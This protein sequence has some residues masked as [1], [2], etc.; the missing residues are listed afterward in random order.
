M[1]LLINT[2]PIIKNCGLPTV[3]VIAVCTFFILSTNIFAANAV[4]KFRS[5]NTEQG[6]SSQNISCVAQDDMGYL[7][8]GTDDGLNRY[9]G[10][11]FRVFRNDPGDTLTI[12]DTR[13]TALL[14]SNYQQQPELWVGTSNGLNR[15]DLRTGH[16]TM[17][18]HDPK[19]SKSISHPVVTAIMEDADGT[20]W[21]G[22]ENGLNMLP[23]EKRKQGEFDRFLDASPE[24]ASYENW[25][26][27][28]EQGP[29]L[30]SEKQI[31]VGTRNGLKKIEISGGMDCR[32]SDYVFSGSNISA[33]E[34]DIR[35]IL[36]KRN[37]DG[38]FL[39]VGIENGDLYKADVFQL[40]ARPKK[41]WK[42]DSFIRDIEIDYYNRIWIAT[43]GGGL[44]RF[45][46]R[47]DKLYNKITFLGNPDL[48]N[49]LSNSNLS[50]LHFDLSGILWVA[51]ENGLNKVIEPVHGF[52]VLTHIPGEERSL[53][54]A[55]IRSLY[56]DSFGIL[57]VGTIANGI[58]RIDRT[59]HTY[60][61]FTAKPGQVGTIP[62]TS[63][64][65]IL[66]DLYGDM[67][68]GTWDGGL[69]K[70]NPDKETFS[71]YANDP[72]D[73]FSVPHNV[74]QGLLEDREG[75]IWLNTGAGLSRYNRK[76]NNFINYSYDP[77]D[78]T[79]ISAGDL[80]SKAMYLDEQDR[81]WVGSYGGGV[82]R[83]DL[84]ISQN[85]DPET[86]IFD[87]IR[88]DPMN[89]SSISS[90]LVISIT[91][92]ENGGREVVWIGTF[93]KGIT[94]IEITNED[95]QEK[96]QYKRY[97]ES[98]GLCDNVIF[99][100]EE[101]RHRE[102]WISTGDGLARFDPDLEHF[103]NYYVED[104]LPSNGFFWGASHQSQAGEMFFGGTEGL[105]YFSPDE[106]M[107]RQLFSPK[108]SI[109]DVRVLNRRLS[110]RPKDY[111]NV[112]LYFD[113]S[114]NLITIDWAL[115]DFIN[116]QKNSFKYRL[117]GLHDNWI[118]NGNMT[119]TT[120]SNLP[121]GN[122]TFRVKGS[123][124]NG[125]ESLL[126]AGLRLHIK[127]PFY[128]TILFQIC[129]ILSLILIIY[130]VFVIRTRVVMARNKQLL[131]INE[132][133]GLLIKK[134]E[135]A[136]EAL[137][138]SLDEKEVLLREIYHRTK[139]NMSVIISLLNLQASSIKKPR[140]TQ[141]FDEIKGR[142]FAM[143][144]VHEQL[145]K[146]KDLSVIDLNLYVRQLI[147]NLLHSYSAVG[148]RINSIIRVDHIEVS[149]DTAVPLGLVLNEI[150]TNSLKYAFPGDR[151][152]EI[153]I[154]AK[155][156]ANQLFLKI[157]DDG[158]GFNKVKLSD[159]NQTLGTR[160]IHTVI[161]DQLE[162]E[163]K[164]D[165]TSGTTYEILLKN[166]QIVRRV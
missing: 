99:G 39:Y 163:L 73:P 143:S 165:A 122:Y 121:G 125:I 83:L 55:G 97:S 86:A 68:F 110:N 27:S 115:F 46:E 132:E 19:N 108:I 2:D 112:D 36:V 84:K 3:R 123:N 142:I 31:W 24:E 70:L 69:F 15:L 102:L 20:I 128:Q 100:I 138:R 157:A 118:P 155:Y 35:S 127:P 137:Q 12:S 107:G 126:E 44:H 106:I 66:E 16:F 119:S 88:H 26:R 150:I 94:K 30:G 48:K 85:L 79:G 32:V 40:D 51:S 4:T 96:L 42:F 136:E 23:A 6:L 80:Q 87:H 159:K 161:E 33:Q 82:S 54:G 50:D 149:I 81:L 76:L 45:Q 77:Q 90:D 139:N 111:N 57:W 130:L 104:G 74:I 56:L 151:H 93:N 103:I 37:K 144:L 156:L 25:V 29:D 5:L 62:E 41:I 133:L 109:S 58:T 67:W 53:S 131:E 63:I 114:D 17:F 162:G 11:I 154:E 34:N 120:F 7:W 18:L 134:R 92:T 52:S 61:H 91:G 8:V 64:T 59:N 43:Y 141:M 124:Y 49:S 60:K 78:S 95:G 9:D 135:H 152:G 75:R 1:Y 89:E 10:N 166:I 22:T 72:A 116:P 145:M 101:D 14:T 47:E 71:H 21:V 105:I 13:V 98:D 146:T 113:Y 117:E 160:I 129:A 28:V 153:T 140:I 148:G 65:T 147:N 38:V 158:V 164:I